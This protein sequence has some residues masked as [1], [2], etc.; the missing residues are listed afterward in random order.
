MNKEFD[1]RICLVAGNRPNLGT[2]SKQLYIVCQQPCNKPSAAPLHHWEWP[3]RPWVRLHIDYMP[4]LLFL[5][6]SVSVN[7]PA[8]QMVGSSPSN[9]SYFSCNH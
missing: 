2:T 7:R 1:Q 6:L 3:E 4:A 9:S 8:L 5:I